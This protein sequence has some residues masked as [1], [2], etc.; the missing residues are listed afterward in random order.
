LRFTADAVS[1]DVKCEAQFT[2]ADRPELCGSAFV[3][4]FN[5]DGGELH[6]QFQRG[7]AACFNVLLHFGV[8]G[9]YVVS[10]QA[11]SANAIS[12]GSPAPGFHALTVVA[13]GLPGSCSTGSLESWSGTLKLTS[14]GAML[15]APYEALGLSL[16]APYPASGQTRLKTFPWVGGLPPAI[17]AASICPPGCNEQGCDE[18]LPYSPSPTNSRTRGPN[19]WNF[20]EA[21]E[22]RAS[23]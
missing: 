3:D 9:Q 1:T 15:A 8:D 5:A 11:N 6:V 13:E 16:Q 22:A 7:A 4:A 23:A 12:L 21:G 20:R 19:T 10:N 18:H 17:C 14:G 2:P